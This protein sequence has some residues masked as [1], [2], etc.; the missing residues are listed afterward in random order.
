MSWVTVRHQALSVNRNYTMTQTATQKFIKDA[1]KGGWFPIAHGINATKEYWM[2]G[3]RWKFSLDDGVV[4]SPEIE[5]IMLDP[6]AWRAVGKVR[7][8]DGKPKHDKDCV[9]MNSDCE[10]KQTHF[11]CPHAHHAC[12]CKS[13]HPWCENMHGLIDALADGK[14]IE[15][16]LSTI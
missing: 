2:S 7:G 8:W 6:D 12:Q 4:I 9:W 11:Y 1:V 13:Y 3:S 10:Y 5:V 14:S 15:D 16:Y